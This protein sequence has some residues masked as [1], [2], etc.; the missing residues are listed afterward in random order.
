MPLPA[1]AGLRFVAFHTHHLSRM[2]PETRRHCGRYGKTQAV[3]RER[4]GR[5]SEETHLDLREKNPSVATCDD[6]TGIVGNSI[7]A[8]QS[9]PLLGGQWPGGDPTQSVGIYLPLLVKCRMFP[10]PLPFSPSTY[11]TSPLL[12]STIPFRFDF[13][14]FEATGRS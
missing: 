11:T 12:D 7:P 3:S 14:P 13:R 8:W 6:S 5:G 4:R 2:L 1:S 10:F 9:S